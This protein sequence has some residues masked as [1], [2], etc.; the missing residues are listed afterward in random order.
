[1]FA[2]KT[3]KMQVSGQIYPIN[4]KQFFKR[5]PILPL[6]KPE[7]PKNDEFFEEQISIFHNFSPRAPFELRICMRFSEVFP[8]SLPLTPGPPGSHS[9][10]CGGGEGGTL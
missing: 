7:S 3:I 5:K 4:M 9:D 8:E 10:H 2:I 6:P 1:M